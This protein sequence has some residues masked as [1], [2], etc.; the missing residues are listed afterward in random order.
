MK[1]QDK[2]LLLNISTTITCLMLDKRFIELGEV[3]LGTGPDL[4]PPIIQVIM[5]DH[6]IFI[7]MVITNVGI[8]ITSVNFLHITMVD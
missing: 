6:M 1:V 3:D 5:V 7:V 4:L 2:E 8:G